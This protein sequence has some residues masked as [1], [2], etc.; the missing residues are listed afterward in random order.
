MSGTCGHRPNVDPRKEVSSMSR[1]CV[2]AVL[3]AAGL[4]YGIG[5]AGAAAPATVRIGVMN[6]MSGPYSDNAGTGSVVAARMAAD[7]FMAA[8][9]GAKVEILAAD[10]KNKADVGSEIVRRWIG[11][12]GVDAVFDIANSAVA[13]AVNDVI[14]NSHAA[15]IASSAA[16]S[17]LTGRFCSPN[18]VQWT[19]DTWAVGH[20]LAQALADEGARSW[21]MIASN[22]SLGRSLVEDTSGSVLRL[23]ETVLGSAAMP[24]NSSDYSSVLVQAAATNPDVIAFA[25]AGGDTAALIKQSSEFG[26]RSPGRMFAALLATTN[27]VKAAGLAASQGLLIIQP[28]Y[29]DMDDASRA[30]A[31]QFEARAHGEVP[32]GFHAGVY[33]S[34]KAYL[35]AVAASGSTD[36]RTVVRAMKA[37]HIHDQVFGDVVVRPDGR[38]IHNM[39][40]F[41]VKGPAQSK[42]PDDVLERVA[43]ITGEQAFRSVAAGGC[44]LGLMR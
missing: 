3:M 4:L 23:K 19:Y 30:W 11:A 21:Y 33:S 8:H 24:V 37:A 18:T 43:T 42:G 17:E 32:T 12:E 41:R 20:T 2:A 34:A 1:R 29:A 25:T 26:L 15:L 28:F 16:T 9:P 10:H 31:R 38:A 36:G 39:Y 35:D 22:N 5:P 14:R 40:L 7:E 27:D 6:D 13:L 44:D